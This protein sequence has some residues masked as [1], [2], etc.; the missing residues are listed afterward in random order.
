MVTPRPPLAAGCAAQARARAARGAG[1]SAA[2]TS[3][4]TAAWLTWSEWAVAD[5][6][7]GTVEP[8]NQ[9]TEAVK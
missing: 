3:S 4:A 8:P 9:M 7:M 6:A 5:V 2:R 1:L